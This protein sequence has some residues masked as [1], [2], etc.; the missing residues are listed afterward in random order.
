MPDCIR[1]NEA[2]IEVHAIDLRIRRHDLQR[3]AEWFDRRGIVSRA[4]ND[5]LR[6]CEPFFDTS[7]KRMLTAIGDC[8]WIYAASRLCW[9]CW[10]RRFR[11][12]R[13]DL[14]RRLSADGLNTSE[15]SSK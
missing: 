10:Q 5:P 14:L 12:I 2:T 11:W 3:T 4:D 6:S 8:L 1:R 13:P 7:D 9:Y 15:L